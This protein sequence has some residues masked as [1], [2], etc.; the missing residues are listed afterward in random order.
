M[1]KITFISLALLG[2]S[3]AAPSYAQLE[4]LDHK[5]ISIGTVAESITPD[6]Q[7]YVVY[8][9]R[10]G[11]GYTGGYWW[12]YGFYN[13]EDGFGTVHMSFGPDVI[14]DGFTA[15]GAAEYLVRFISVVSP[16]APY[17]EYYVQF[18][19]GNYMWTSTGRSSAVKTVPTIEEASTLYAY[20]INGEAGHFSFLT[21][22]GEE[23]R[24]DQNGAGNTVVLWGTGEA[25]SS[26]GNSDF[27]LLS[28]DLVEISDWDEAFTECARTYS[29]YIDYYDSFR[30]GTTYGCYDADAIA[31]FQAALDQAALIDSPE[32]GVFTAEELLEMTQTIIDTYNAVLAT[33][34]PLAMEI[35]DGYYFF[36]NGLEYTEETEEYED[37]GT[38]ELIPGET[39]VVTKGMYSILDSD[40]TIY[41]RWM[42]TDRSCPFLWK[43][44]A[45][46]DKTYSVV[47]V[48][49]DATF[50][51]VAK[52]TNVTMSVDGENLMVFDAGLDEFDGLATIRVSTQAENNYYYLHCGGHSDGA[53]VSGSIVGW[54]RGAD[55]SYWAL[56]PVSEEEA[57]A[58]IEEYAPIKE[59]EQRY[60]Y[61]QTMIS[62]ARTKM[63]IAED[64][65]LGSDKLITSVDQ[66]S[67]PY[68]EDSEGSIE[69]LLDEDTSTFWHSEWTDGE[70]P[71]GT[72]YLQ[73]ELLDIYDDLAFVFSR[74]SADNDHITQWGVY[75]APTY[76]AEKDE[77]TMLAEIFTPYGG[78]VETLTSDAFNT[79][80]FTILRFYIDDT[81]VVESKGG[82]TRGYG[83]I[84]EFQLYEAFVNETSQKV[85]L[86]EIYSNLEDAIALAD[87]EGE[88][89]TVDTYNTLKDAYDAFI[90][91]FVDPAELRAVI[92]EA[93]EV[94]IGVVIGDNPGCWTDSSVGGTLGVT[95]EE[96]TTYDASGIYSQ[97]QS[98][99]Y[100]ET[101][102]KQMDA[103]ADEAIKVETGKW[104]EFRYATLDEIEAYGWSTESG[105][106]GTYG[107]ELYGKYL[108]VATFDEDVYVV[109]P[110]EESELD[111]IC[112]GHRLYFLDKGEM[113]YEDYA[114]F[115]FIN[116]GD[117]AYIMQNKATGLFLKAAGTSGG[118]TL[119]IHPTLFYVSPLGYGENLI[120]G[121]TLE[122]ESQN[123]LHAQ[124][125]YNTLVT[126]STATA[127]SNSGFYI[128]DIGEDVASDYD[129]TDFN[130]SLQYGALNVFCYP[131]SVSANEGDVF[132]VYVD[133]TVVT[134]VTLDDNTA[135]AGQPFI[136]VIG[137]LEDYDAEAEEEIVSFK[138]GYDIEK[139]A[140]TV[141]R[142]VGK[143]YGETVG[144]GKLIASGNEFTVCRST[145]T[146]S[147]NSAYIN[148]SYAFGDVITI[149][150]SDEKFNSVEST[151]AKVAQD[152][153][154]YSIDGKLLGKGN[155]NSL[156]SLGKGI[157]IV[158]GVKVAV[159]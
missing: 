137:G 151:I 48:A 102:T 93:T 8:N 78:G 2:F 37:P 91:A 55:A 46:G 107:D 105:E 132:G 19:T 98:D 31:A 43:I 119:S 146:V 69:A 134:L 54:G 45:T 100:V 77:C 104:Y 114:K 97:E 15:K 99:V 75:G 3:F 58:I 130:M 6:T 106:A 108:T 159:K 96:A 60:Q 95:I 61:A 26:G 71:A 82:V 10:T 125:D 35:A 29:Q 25:E 157:Y 41:A 111:N 62:D 30:V 120:S 85:A 144:S 133:D 50:N 101:L 36:N 53:G 145:S 74:R 158:N 136:F 59:A 34:I 65:R 129:G 27:T 147:D 32:A 123:N 13:E 118:V 56:E 138:H 88:D 38:G 126:W 70:V 4:E 121:V 152:A 51:N 52:S 12:D 40:G 142:L 116:V 89:I 80:G 28:I 117:T 39:I 81:Y 14:Y 22:E 17:D 127:G 86:G 72:H 112:V 63:K 148:G 128:E 9:S 139:E 115:R 156:K 7:W 110:M 11:N 47:N 79:G 149:E 140:Q 155:L 16:N 42:T 21:T 24:L 154:I 109:D 122:G 64:T 84:S 23:W 5:A 143:Y 49:T 150:F 94:S 67:S 1:K 76:D 44:T 33:Y 20:C 87:A 153:D 131:V 103:L 68:T 90:A 73:V 135:E 141:G 57:L 92:A 124:R 18:G 83:H 113:R 66:L